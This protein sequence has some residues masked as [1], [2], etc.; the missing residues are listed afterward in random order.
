MRSFSC[1]RATRVRAR[2]LSPLLGA[3]ALHT[4]HPFPSLTLGHS[5]L[6][7]GASVP[8][9]PLPLPGHPAPPL[10]CECGAGGREQPG[11]SPRSTAS[12]AVLAVASLCGVRCLGSDLPTQT[13][14]SATNPPNDLVSLSELLFFLSGIPQGLSSLGPSS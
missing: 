3:P 2:P 7:R 13:S 1:W 6:T 5:F 14:A 9:R 10:P 4:L 8:P 11:C 12:G